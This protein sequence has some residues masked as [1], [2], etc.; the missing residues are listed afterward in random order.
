M[1][2]FGMVSLSPSVKES[3]FGDTF[4][5]FISLR[6]YFMIQNLFFFVL[7]VLDSLNI[8]EPRSQKLSN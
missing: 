3:L 1:I 5:K 8:S 6:K 2:S 4:L 7:Y